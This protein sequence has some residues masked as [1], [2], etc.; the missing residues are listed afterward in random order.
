MKFD[1]MKTV[2]IAD[3]D[4]ASRELLRDALEASGFRL[5]EASDGREALNKIRTESPDLVLLD[6]EMPL[7]D[8]FAVLRAARDLDPP[9][10]AGFIAL[11]AFAMESDRQ[12]IEKAG[13][14]GYV[15]KPISISDV[16]KQVEAMLA[17]KNRETSA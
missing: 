1:R 15:A 14:D 4:Q 5:L 7:L 9:S 2:L 11:T 8:G 6:I 12:R 3:D 13:F 16:R 17:G 10:S